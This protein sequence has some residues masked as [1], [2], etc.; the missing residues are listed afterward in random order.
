MMNLLGLPTPYLTGT[1]D[2][3]P[4]SGHLD[5]GTYRTPWS[6]GNVFS[7]TCKLSLN[8][9]V[10]DDL[11]IKEQPLYVPESYDSVSSLQE[12]AEF[13]PSSNPDSLNELDLDEI[14]G[15]SIDSEDP[16]QET[17]SKMSHIEPENER[18]DFYLP[19]EIM[20]VDYLKQFK[21]HLPLLKAKLSR[22]MTLPVADPL[23][24]LKGDSIS[25]HAILRCCEPY[26][27]P[28]QMHIIDNGTCTISLEDLSKEL[29]I[30]E[31]PLLLPDVLESFSSEQ[32]D[33]T[34]FSNICDLMR[35]IP[36]EIDEQP[37]V[38]EMMQKDASATQHISQVEMFEEQNKDSVLMEELSESAERI[39]CYVEMELDLILT[40][41][42]KGCHTS[43]CLS[44]S[45]LCREQL[46]PF[47]QISLGSLR[48][49]RKMERALWKAEKH[50]T[51]V[52]SFML[53]EP[54]SYKHAVDFQPFPEAL[55]LLKQDKQCL[56]GMVEMESMFG[57]GVQ[58]IHLCNSSDF[59]ESIRSDFCS[60]KTDVEEFRKI[61]PEQ[62]FP[63]SS[64]LNNSPR[65]SQKKQEDPKHAMS[66][67][68][69][70]T[71][72]FVEAKTAIPSFPEPV[73]NSI[74]KLQDYRFVKSTPSKGNSVD[75]TAKE[76]SQSQS[77]V[78]QQAVPLKK[79]NSKSHFGAKCPPQ[80][81]LD[82]LSTFIMLR[83]Q[84]SP[85]V[86]ATPAPSS[87]VIPALD[88]KE[89]PH[90]EL[91]ATEQSQRMYMN[92]AV[93]GNASR[94]Q[95]RAGSL[96][97]VQLT[98]HPVDQHISLER[99]VSVVQVQATESQYKA[100]CELLSFA[101]PHL[102]F[103]QQLGLN[104]QVWGDFQSL[105]SDQT[106]FLVKQQEK[107]LCRTNADNTDLV[108]DEKLFNQ[109]ALI[110][111][112]VTFKELLLKCGLNIG[113]RYLKTNIGVEERLNQLLKRLEIILYLSH[114][115]QETN[116]KLLELQQLLTTWIHNR[117]GNNFTDKILVI[118][119]DPEDTRDIVLKCLSQV[120]GQAVAAL[121]LEKD[122]IKL[123]GA[124]VVSSLCDSLCALVCE[125]H[126]GPDFPWQCFSLVVEYDHLGQSP[127][128]KVCQERG[129]IHVSFNTVLPGSEAEKWS[130]EDS[131]PYVL[132]VTEGLC[133]L[134]LRT[135]ES[136]FNITVMERNHSMSL[137]MLG[138]TQQ[139]TVITVDECTAIVIQKQDELCQ[140]R[141][142]EGLVMRLTALSLQYSCCWLI[143][144]CPDSQGGGLSNEAFSNLVL[145]YSSLVLFSM[146]SEDLDVKVMM[147]SEVMEIARWIS[148]ISFYTLMTSDGDPVSCL[149]REWLAV[150]QS[151]EEKCLLHF[152][153][154][155]PLVSQI[156]LRRAPNIE[157]LLRAS[158][159]QLKELLP[160]VPL[161]VLKL[162]SDTTSLYTQT[163]A[164]NPLEKQAVFRESGQISAKNSLWIN[165][166]DP[167][168]L[169]SSPQQDTSFLF[170]AASVHNSFSD[171]ASAEGEPKRH[172][173]F[174]MN[175]SFASPDT[176][177]HKSDLWKEER[178]ELSGWGSR[179]GAMGKVVGREE[180]WRSSTHPKTSM[181]Y[182]H[183]DNDSPFKADSTFGYNQ[184]NINCDLQQMSNSLSS[185]AEVML[186]GQGLST[187][188]T[189]H[190]N[191]G[192]MT[193]ASLN[194]GSKSFVGRERKRSGDAGPLVGTEMTPIKK[195][196]LS[197]ERVTGRSDGQTRLK[198]L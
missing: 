54:H 40:P 76:Q 117:T 162:F 98:S 58:Q 168:H 189:P 46:S 55:K 102:S 43:I 179:A 85:A 35:I 103:A 27:Q 5:E 115:K 165:T 19:E 194:Y 110:H 9:S 10:L 127:W 188:E 172:F 64:I 47:Q 124:S 163:T 78:L 196:R 84:Q 15:I 175:P 13:V 11:R 3:Y 42:S 61:S 143:L 82:P 111:V 191:G 141:T 22:L 86:T 44:T 161:K 41:A 90:C 36:E 63:I 167:Q 100:Y 170:G 142:S 59:I 99:Q 130:L 1:S 138:G 109:V 185:P 178:D 145:V 68:Q 96:P 31:E 195:S 62:D 134:L 69:T 23:L 81:D 18:K 56:V 148:R 119:I 72:K 182:L 174:K 180:F 30:N 177:V 131:V 112:L 7:T 104:M 37:S 14:G 122:K 74:K 21:R 113:I 152:P 39:K 8:G 91:Q 153:C 51:F 24:D 160:E 155:N 183:S 114:K 65:S 77:S 45:G 16:C 187:N 129:L 25:K 135:L 171:T 133:P 67:T 97:G 53:T 186:W 87:A 144:H 92:V 79:D 147:V 2:I 169:D 73:L 121:D 60:S 83:S 166:C 52:L 156:M 164:I 116:S 50:P 28:P 12:D 193:R 6:R 94:G 197:Y 149:D 158:L 139:Y 123:N 49:Q 107:A 128:A 146:K 198:L 157:W 106:H 66:H 105:S 33:L 75:H 101:Q 32:K 159:S 38:L 4:H 34:A 57:A 181:K 184:V 118:T 95:S 17:F 125:Q 48:A 20:E 190:N 173:R 93:S 26:K 140:E 89:T 150:I 137:Q 176:Y 192:M 136:T 151:N 126:I 70:M 120:I 154:I 29:L 71:A 132:L 88:V 80:K 108:R